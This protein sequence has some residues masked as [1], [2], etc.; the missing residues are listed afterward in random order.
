M[1]EKARQFAGAGAET[2]SE[3][4]RT[5]EEVVLCHVDVVYRVA[6]RLTRNS[7]QAEDLVQETFMRAYQAFERFE[8][9][10]YGAKPWLLKILHNTFFADRVRASKAPAQLGEMPA[11]DFAAEL[12]AEPAPVFAD[13]ELDWENFDEELKQ[14]VESLSPEYRYTLLLWALGDLSYKEIAEVTGCAIGTVMSR[15]FRARQQLR[16]AMPSYAEDRGIPRELDT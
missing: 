1:A 12:P 2:R 14:G 6:V 3:A 9:R 8:L 10:Q 4:P 11:D 15:L 7:H 5:F 13:G 16:Q